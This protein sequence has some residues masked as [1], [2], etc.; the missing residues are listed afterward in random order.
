ARPHAAGA[1]PAGATLRPV[2]PT[3][4]GRRP[5]PHQLADAVLGPRRRLRPGR[6][7]SGG[8]PDLRRAPLVGTG[9]RATVLGEA[10]A[11]VDGLDAGRAGNG[12]ADGHALG[13][14]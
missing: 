13:D 3:D 10:D 6:D 2:Q 14:A 5:L 11:G 9:V 8:L 12:L 4:A 1:R 7:L